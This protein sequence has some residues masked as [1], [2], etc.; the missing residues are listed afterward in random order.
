VRLVPG[1]ART[2]KWNSVDDFTVIP[3]IFVEVD[4]RQE[5]GLCTCLVS[6]PDEKKFC[7]RAVHLFFSIFFL[8]SI[9]CG[10]CGALPDSHYTGQKCDQ[11]QRGKYYAPANVGNCSNHN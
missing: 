2:W 6:G 5:I 7:P 3:G 10:S 11:D 9:L 1:C 4:N 8:E